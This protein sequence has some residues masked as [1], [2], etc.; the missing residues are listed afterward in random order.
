MVGE[1]ISRVIWK[2]AQQWL[3]K[4]VRSCRIALKLWNKETWQV[5]KLAIYKAGKAV[6]TIPLF[7]R[8]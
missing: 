2:T 1:S 7:L 3:D 6:Y 8:R 5:F 4:P